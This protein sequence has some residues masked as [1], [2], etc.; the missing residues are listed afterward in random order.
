MYLA[1]NEEKFL[2]QIY[3]EE[4]FG[5]I[6]LKQST[7]MMEKE[8]RKKGAAIGFIYEDS[9]IEPSFNPV[10]DKKLKDNLAEKNDS[11]SDDSDLDF[12]SLFFI[13]YTD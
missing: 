7:E 11:D 13:A 6:A 1:V 8:K 4:Q 10:P 5:P 12:G 3:L 9:T 2:H